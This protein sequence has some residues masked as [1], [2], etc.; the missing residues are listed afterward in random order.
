MKEFDLTQW[1]DFVRDLVDDEESAQMQAALLSGSPKAHRAVDMLHR[2]A[3]VLEADQQQ[4]VPEHAVHLAKAIASLQRP[5][6]NE[7]GRGISDILRSKILRYLPFEITFDNQLEPAVAGTR[8]LQ[9]QD[10][11]VS[12][13]ASGFVIDLRVERDNNATAVVGHVLRETQDGDDLEPAASLSVVA[14]Q[15]GRIVQT[16]STGAFGEFQTEEL[17]TDPL[18]LCFLVDDA[19][20]I[21]FPITA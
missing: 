19:S 18:K 15:G 20:C 9:A 6:E 8:S 12:L 10:R 16:M 13:E 7:E 5:A 3:S 21:E 14:M 17:T 11:Q 4:P 1:S 2:V